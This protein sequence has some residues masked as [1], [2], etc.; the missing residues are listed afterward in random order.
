MLNSNSKKA[1]ENIKK[2]ILDHVDF[3]SY[4]QYAYIDEMAEDNAAGIRNIDLFSVV[5]E[6][7]RA[8]VYSE[9]IKYDNRR[10]SISTYEYFKDW[11]QGL[12]S[13]LDTC[14]YYN[15]SAADDLAEI[16]EETETEKGRFSEQQA[17][18]KLTYLMYREI[19]RK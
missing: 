12:P 15:R 8:C 7:I 6:A 9:K 10:S 16:L 11:C 17:E 19:Y 5:R 3:S 2:Y 4:E 14:Y 18:E 1:K 13:V